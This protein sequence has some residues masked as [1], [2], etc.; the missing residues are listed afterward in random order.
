M[1]QKRRRHHHVTLRIPSLLQQYLKI[2]KEE[3]V[4]GCEKKWDMQYV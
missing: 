2:E 4:I 1:R 3:K